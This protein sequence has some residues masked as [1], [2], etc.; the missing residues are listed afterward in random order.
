MLS[1]LNNV[2]MNIMERLS[3]HVKKDI[4]LQAAGFDGEPGVLHKVGKRF[5]KVGDHYYMPAAMQ[6]I[7]LLGASRKKNGTRVNVRTLYANVFEAS[8][9]RTGIDFLELAVNRA[10]E[11]EELCLLVPLNKVIGVEML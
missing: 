8:L 7:V 4:A 9:I 6:E 2:R 5:I 3:L 10:E 11:E 1:L